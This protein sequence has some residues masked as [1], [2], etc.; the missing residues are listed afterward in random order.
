MKQ[1]IIVFVDGVPMENVEEVNLVFNYEGTFNDDDLGI[2]VHI[3]L[4]KEKR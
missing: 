2:I 1:K 3:T 4:K